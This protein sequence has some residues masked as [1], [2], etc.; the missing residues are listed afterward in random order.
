MGIPI[1]TAATTGVSRIDR[2]AGWKRSLYGRYHLDTIRN[3][4]RPLRDQGKDRQDG[5]S[6]ST[7]A[8]LILS[9]IKLDRILQRSIC[10]P[11]SIRI[12][13]TSVITAREDSN[14]RSSPRM[15]GIVRDLRLT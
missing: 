5:I 9:V 12:I 10:T 15:E 2:D 11:I 7:I 13:I 3:R 14:S 1:P 6:V 4:S 8:I